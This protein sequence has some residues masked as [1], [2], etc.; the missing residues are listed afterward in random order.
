MNR[1]IKYEIKKRK[2]RKVKDHSTNPETIKIYKLIYSCS[3]N[4]TYQF[5]KGKLV[6]KKGKGITHYDS[7]YSNSI[8]DVHLMM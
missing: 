7:I 5:D 6:D 3:C 2:T 4:N 1:K 8:V